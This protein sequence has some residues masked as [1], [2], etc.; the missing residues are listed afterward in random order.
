MVVLSLARKVAF[1]SLEASSKLTSVCG[2]YSEK[3]IVLP[4]MT[5][6]NCVRSGV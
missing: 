2:L 5:A 4:D 6:R 1:T 3:M